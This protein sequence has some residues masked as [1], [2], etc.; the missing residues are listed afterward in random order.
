MSFKNTKLYNTRFIEV[1][2]ST[3][4]SITSTSATLV[5]FDTIRGDTGHGV[6]LVSAGNGRLRL[7]GGRFYHI[8]GSTTIDKD[9]A[10]DQYS[11][12]WYNTSGTELIE[13]E[14]AFRTF[15]CIVVGSDKFY[16][17]LHCQLVVNPTSD[18]DYDLKVDGE[19]GT[20]LQDGTRLFIIEMSES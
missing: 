8:V 14:G 4:Q 7:S 5:N 1:S 9:T 19:T 2:L 11:A 15:E 13:S 20:L 16:Q 18:T 3:D 12:R 6:S 17:C 10:S